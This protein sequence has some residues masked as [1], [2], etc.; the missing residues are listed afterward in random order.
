MHLPPAIAG[1]TRRVEI[2]TLVVLLL[3][4]GAL[5][6]FIALAAEMIEGDEDGLQGFILG[7]EDGSANGLLGQDINSSFGG[8]LAGTADHGAA[9]AT[10]TSEAKAARHDRRGSDTGDDALST[11]RPGSTA[12]AH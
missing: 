3:I 4:A 12:T 8:G 9:G 1:A 5:W 6:A 7:D 11:Q 2:V 10:S